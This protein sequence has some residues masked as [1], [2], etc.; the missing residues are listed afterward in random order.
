MILL[1]AASVRYSVRS[2]SIESPEIAH[3]AKF[4]TVISFLL[5]VDSTT[6]SFLALAAFFG[7]SF[8][9]RFSTN[10]PPTAVAVTATTHT[11]AIAFLGTDQRAIRF[12]VRLM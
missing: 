6:F 2:F 10:T 11:P 4:G 5:T 8:V 7:S 9:G 3:A 12:G 1:P